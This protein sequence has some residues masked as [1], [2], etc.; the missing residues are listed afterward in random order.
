MRVK[1]LLMVAVVSGAFGLVA[2][3]PPAHACTAEFPSLAC[4]YHD[5]CMVAGPKVCR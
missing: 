5:V 1:A 3:A 4:V 2:G